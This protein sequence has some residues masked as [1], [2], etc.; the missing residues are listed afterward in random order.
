MH[1]CLR[2]AEVLGNIFENLERDYAALAAVARTCTTFKEPALDGLW[3]RQNTLDNILKCLPTDAWKLETDYSEWIRLLRPLELEDWERPSQY[4]HRVKSMCL[5]C[6]YPGFPLYHTLKALLVLFRAGGAFPNLRELVWRPDEVRT[7]TLRLI[8]PLLCPRLTR[9]EIII[10]LSDLETIATLRFPFSDLECLEI[11]TE[12][13]ASVEPPPTCIPAPLSFL[14]LSPFSRLR[15]LVLPSIDR[16]TFHLASYLPTLHF[17]Q[18]TKQK[19][20]TW[21]RTSPEDKPLAESNPFPSLRVLMLKDTKF[22]VGVA[23]LSALPAWDLEEFLIETFYA[24]HKDT[25]QR[26]YHVVASRLSP[27]RLSSLHIGKVDYGEE[28]AVPPTDS[29]TEYVVVGSDVQPLFRFDNLKGICLETAAGF[30]I[31]DN[32]IWQLARALPKLTHLT[33]ISG[34][35]FMTPPRTSLDALRAFAE[36]CN[37]LGYLELGVDTARGVPP[38]SAFSTA[39]TSQYALRYLVVNNSPISHADPPAIAQ[40]LS[41][42]FPNLDNIE[43]RDQD[44]WENPD[45]AIMDENEF[46]EYE[47]YCRWAEVKR[48]LPLFSLARWEERSRGERPWARQGP[49]KLQR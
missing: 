41:G 40:Y 6:S 37:D 32:T 9:V 34:S 33:L 42:I 16:G 45:H 25:L 19:L 24:P 5:D 21:N 35:A 47:I 39:R 7:K 18:L 2:I 48:L 27:K 26:L 23:V 8:R 49:G 11:G 10:P 17:L 14:S 3:K 1:H 44:R 36:H 46:D 43:T 13:C 12:N 31:D 38:F 28:I 20:S 4:A 15:T 22:E 30:Q 29:V